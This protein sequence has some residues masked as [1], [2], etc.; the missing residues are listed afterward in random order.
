MLIWRIS[1]YADL[2][3]EGG[4]RASARWHTLGHPIVYLAEHPAL[5][6]LENLVG[7]EVDP[8]DLPSTYQLLEVDLPDDI[9]VSP[10]GEDDLSRTN[11]DWRMDVT[12]TRSLGDQWLEGAGTAIRRVPSVILPRSTNF[13]VN[14]LHRDAR[15]LRIVSTLRATY[16]PRLFRGAS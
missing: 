3:G 8:D 2:S 16:D 4:R 15:R 7:S 9:A 12:F 1:N 5:A 11:T 14:P 13:L 6:L 10:L